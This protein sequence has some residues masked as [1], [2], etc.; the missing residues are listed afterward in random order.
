[1]EMCFA[2]AIVS[3]VQFF[4]MEL[5]F[6]L[7]FNRNTLQMQ[8]SVAAALASLAV[9]PE[10]PVLGQVLIESVTLVVTILYQTASC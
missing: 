7:E 5:C 4:E 9:L 1:M 3:Y 8:F 2:I 6:V 10:A